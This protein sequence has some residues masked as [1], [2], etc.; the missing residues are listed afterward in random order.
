MNVAT[1]VADVGG[2]TALHAADVGGHAALH[3]ADVGG[4]IAIKYGGPAAIA[5]IKTALHAPQIYSKIN[6]A[7]GGKLDVLIIM[8][9]TTAAGAAG[10]LVGAEFAGVGEIVGG[11]AGAFAGGAL[12]K[13]AVGLLHSQDGAVTEEGF[14]VM[15]ESEQEAYNAKL[16]VKKIEI[17]KKIKQ[18]YTKMK[19]P[20]EKARVEAMTP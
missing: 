3:A 16:E 17:A 5:A 6:S 1:H 15:S 7:L 2:H 10:A 13:L 12:G 11:P 19:D 20:K 14:K 9:C 4:H 8:G 18:I